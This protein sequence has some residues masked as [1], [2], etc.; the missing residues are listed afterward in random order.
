MNDSTSVVVVVRPYG[1]GGF[2]LHLA[3]NEDSPAV[4]PPT[5]RV[6]PVTTSSISPGASGFDRTL[7]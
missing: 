4:A 6:V 3:G 5:I 2:S 1:S 7:S